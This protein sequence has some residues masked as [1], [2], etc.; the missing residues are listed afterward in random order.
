MNGTHIKICEQDEKG[1]G[2]IRIKGRHVMMGYL[3][4]EEAT[5]ECID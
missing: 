3:N 1:Q 5:K 2:E 4:N